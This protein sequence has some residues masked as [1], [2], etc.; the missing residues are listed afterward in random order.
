MGMLCLHELH[1]GCKITYLQQRMQKNLPLRPSLSSGPPFPLV[2]HLLCSL[3]LELAAPTPPH[4]ACGAG[5]GGSRRPLLPIPPGAGAGGS[6]RLLIPSVSPPAASGSQRE[7]RR[8][9]ASST[10]RPR[11]PAVLD[12]ACAGGRGRGAPGGSRA[13][14]RRPP[15]PPPREGHGAPATSAPSLP[16]PPLCLG[17]GPHGAGS[18]RGGGH[19]RARA[20][21]CAPPVELRGSLKRKSFA[22]GG[23]A[24][25]DG[26]AMVAGTVDGGSSFRS[27]PRREGGVVGTL[28]R[29][30]GCV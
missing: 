5:A 3:P 26:A 14:R 11:C 4:P 9:H 18:A 1:R 29:P 27:E 19:G 30:C 28:R 21:I 15:P 12:L 2:P 24:A 13:A 17:E 25:A 23:P 6:G 16:P 10:Q 20:R 22:R 8:G 7:E